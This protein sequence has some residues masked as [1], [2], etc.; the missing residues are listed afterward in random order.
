[1][2]TLAFATA[3]AALAVVAPAGADNPQLRLTPAD[4]AYA[5]EVVLQKDDM[6][7]IH[8]AWQG[9][10]VKP[11][12]EGDSCGGARNSDLVLTG[13]AS[14]RFSNAQL[15]IESDA[16]VLQSSQMV[17]ADARRQPP[18]PVVLEC[19]RD[20]YAGIKSWTIDSVETLPFPRIGQ[21]TDAQRV[22][23]SHPNADSLADDYID[24]DVGR[25]EASLYLHYTYDPHNAAV[26]NEIER[27]LAKLLLATATP[28]KIISWGIVLANAEAKAGH[29][30]TLS[31]LT[32]RPDKVHGHDNSGAISIG[33]PPDAVT[34]TATLPGEP[35]TGS[36]KGGCHWQIP[37]D[38]KGKTLAVLA[39]VTLTGAT[40]TISVPVPVG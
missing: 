37:A 7:N 9:G 24:I 11:S 8:R 35:L 3:V 26:V 39:H 33:S 15:T 34:C 6:P 38:A 28:P 21:K 27:Q 13:T 2:K 18:A 29:G 25:V 12:V 32:L 36:G 16:W 31:G 1:M 19:L 20:S 30:F 22:I 40:T 4:Q 14:T 5:R 17:R 10:S 23:L